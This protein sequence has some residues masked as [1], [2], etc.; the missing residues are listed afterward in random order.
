MTITEGCLVKIPARCPN[1]IRSY[2]WNKDMDK[3]LN[4]IQR[5]KSIR[6][7]SRVRLQINERWTWHISDL[8]EF[9]NEV[10]VIPVLFDPQSLNLEK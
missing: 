9:N 6:E 5:V 4:T 10:I 7:D 2:S 8:E 1:T 3:Y